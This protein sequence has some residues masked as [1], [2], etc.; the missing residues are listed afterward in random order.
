MIVARILR[1]NLLD[2]F[3][4]RGC[5]LASKLFINFCIHGCFES[6]NPEGLKINGSNL[7]NE[8]HLPTSE[9][10]TAVCCLSSLNLERYDEWK[11]TSL[12]KDLIRYLDNV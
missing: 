7:C 6:Y 1:S 11:D 12:V 4:D 9:D 5:C 3:E 8:I 2:S 10:R